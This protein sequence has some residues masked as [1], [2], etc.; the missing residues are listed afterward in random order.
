M[1]RFARSWFAALWIAAFFTRLAV[2]AQSDRAG[3]QAHLTETTTLGPVVASVRVEP[4]KPLIGDIVEVT[5]E[6]VSE[7]DVEVLM[8]EF[9]EALDR[10]RILD[11]VPRQEIT[12]DGNTLSTQRYRLQPPFSGKQS[13]PPILI[14]FVDNRPG[15]KPAPDDYDAFELLTPRV[16]FVV[17]S[18]TPTDATADLKPPLGELQIRD[19]GTIRRRW[20][21]RIIAMALIAAAILWRWLRRRPKEHK[22]QSAYEIARDRLDALMQRPLPLVGKEATSFYVELS[23]IVRQYL[24]DRFELRAPELTTEEFL[25]VVSESPDLHREHQLLLQEFLRQADLVKFAGFKPDESTVQASIDAAN[26]FINDTQ[27]QPETSD[28]QRQ[29]TSALE[30]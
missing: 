13:I 30:V 29:S 10:Y 2:H 12:D 25:D 23:D 21:R 5:I 26:R 27:P 24:E 14:E 3:E 7:P 19:E 6:V 16:D 4:A 1:R 8:P 17:E 15:Q 22:Q 28:G 18:V 9:G 20:T 11:F